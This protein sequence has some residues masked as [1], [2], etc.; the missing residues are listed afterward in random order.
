MNLMWLAVA[1][2][3][4]L[5]LIILTWL[6]L[7]SRSHRPKVVSNKHP[8]TDAEIKQGLS[9]MAIEESTHL[10][11]EEFREELRNRA[12][13]NFDNLMRQNAPA[14]KQ[15]LDDTTSKLNEYIAKNIDSKLNYEIATYSRALKAA[16]QR[17]IESLQK[18][19]LDFELDRHQFDD[20]L[21]KNV[22]GHEEALIKAYEQNMAKIIEHYLLQALGDQF[23]LKTQLP[24]IIARMEEDK[25]AM[26]QDMR[27]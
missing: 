7:R 23:D 25:E 11:N 5:L 21:K 26:A 27:L 24:S 8:K 12:R 3:A 20:M 17:A 14:F 19:V 13:L 15:S 4:V 18:S 6:I 22:A 9:Q 2:G 16:Q 10:F 1:G